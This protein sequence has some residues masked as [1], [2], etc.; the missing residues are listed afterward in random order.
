MVVEN[1]R[2]PYQIAGLR[3]KIITGLKL[4]EFKRAE[5][6]VQLLIEFDVSPII[7][8]EYLS[9]IKLTLGMFIWTTSSYHPSQKPKGEMKTAR[10]YMLYF[11]TPSSFATLEGGGNFTLKN[12][13][14]HFMDI[15]SS[16]SILCL[17]PALISIFGVY[18][19]KY[20]V[21]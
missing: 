9:K 2:H 13:W 15:L 14:L 17:F 5:N 21:T 18:M 8:F 11:I 4:F 6:R 7:V 19:R 10:V 20:L 1:P 16:F 12:Y 3:V